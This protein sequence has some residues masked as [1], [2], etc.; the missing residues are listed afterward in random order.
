MVIVILTVIGAIVGA[1][2]FD[3]NDGGLWLGAALGALL[4]WVVRLEQRVESLER[5]QAE[6]D[7]RP[8][9]LGSD[10]PLAGP[11]ADRAARGHGVGTAY[12]AARASETSAENAS[13]PPRAREADPRAATPRIVPWYEAEGSP[14]SDGTRDS[15]A[16]RPI[17]PSDRTPRGGQRPGSTTRP[18]LLERGIDAIGAWFTTGNVPVKVG[19]VLSVFGVGFLVKE[20]IDRSWLTLPIS[21]RLVG[22]AAFGVG[23]LALGWR[24][25]STRRGYGLSLQGGGIAILY[26]TIYAAFEIYA[27]IPAATAFALMV[28]VT[29]AAGAL[30]VPQDS[31]ALAVLG[32][33][34]G[35][36]APVLASDG[37]GNHVVLFGYYAILNCAVFGIAWFKAWRVLNVLGFVF[38]FVIGSLWGYAAY[39]PEHFASTEPFLILFVAMY[40]VIPVLF[41]RRVPPTLRG[42]VDGTLVFGTPMAGFGL[43]TRLVDS[44]YGLALSAL[45]LAAT[46]AALAFHLFRRR[47]PGFRALAEAFFG[48]GIVFVTVALP[49]ALDARWTS[50]AWALQGAAMVWLGARQERRL[51]LAAGVLLQGLAALAYFVQGRHGIAGLAV[52]NGDY[53]GAVLI[54]VAAWFS[55]RVLD[56][57]GSGEVSRFARG[58]TAALLAWGALWWLGAG[59]VEIERFVPSEA[60][61]SAALGLGAG[62][63][64][65]AIAAARQLA[66]PRIAGLGCLLVP[67]LATGALLVP[68]QGHPLGRYGWLAW[69]AVFAVHFFYLASWEERF[70]RLGAVL[71]VAGYWTIAWLAGFEVY[72]QVDRVTSGVWAPAAALATVSVL[73]LAT[74]ALRA[75]LRW[76]LGEHPRAYVGV[77]GGGAI[78]AAAAGVLVLNLESPG[79]AAPLAYVPLLNPLELAS[80][81]V[82]STAV[83]WHA[84]AR[85]VGAVRS[86][87]GRRFA[88]AAALAGL[89]LLTMVVARSVHHFAG[90]P[91]ELERLAQSDV[92]QAAISIVWGGVALAGMVAGASRRVR[93]I[94]MGGA[95]LM[96]IVVA[97]LLIVDLGNTGTVE[98]VISF[99]GVGILLLVVGYFAPVPPRS[100]DASMRPSARARAS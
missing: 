94:W 60:W 13:P 7:S 29:T 87:D 35:F 33:V 23:M 72:W 9:P 58:A 79:A 81:L 74:L 25:R 98:R 15:M 90:V 48:L 40:L 59:L 28:L 19:V 21:A 38:T 56:S 27:L 53:L 96:G 63:V 42:F 99:L 37:S 1:E 11:A 73:V 30:A 51:A 24:L 97:K 91:F 31:R 70:A 82:L 64:A 46:Y 69:P 26:V 77:G 83:R 17:D 76:P 3:G 55:S 4:G 93:A 75:R 10:E 100:P 88:A 20:A 49:L 6:R 84:A 86:V 43:Q 18:G 65:L 80:L 5:L 54:A 92:F 78:G 71:H 2:F 32:I 12:R 89:Y 62:T 45:A 66:W 36:M 44:E 14:E 57:V 34:G 61:L 8:A 52:L 68:V 39:R 16:E 67:M 95:V 22:V 41:A 85:A 47:G 50:A